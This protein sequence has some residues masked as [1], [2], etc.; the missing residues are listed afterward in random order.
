MIYDFK[1]TLYNIIK[2]RYDRV[3]NQLPPENTQYPFVVFSVE[4]FPN[5]PGKIMEVIIDIW[6][7][8][9]NQISL[10]RTSYEL[11]EDLDFISHN[12]GRFYFHGTVKYYGDVPTQEEQLIRRQ[13]R[14]RYQ[15]YKIYN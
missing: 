15:A 11:L 3:Y 5:T 6:D 14:C 7:T 10:D 9:T 4:Q 8:E 2:T 12:E 1:A 13:I